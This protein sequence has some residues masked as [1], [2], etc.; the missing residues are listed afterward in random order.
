M[1]T[2]HCPTLPT[3]GYWI[4]GHGTSQPYCDFRCQSGYQKVGNS[5]VKNT[6]DNGSTNYPHCNSCP[7]GQI[8][9]HGQ[10]IF[11]QSCGTKPSFSSWIQGHGNAYPNCTWECNTGF[12]RSGNACLPLSCQNGA[13]NYPNCNACANGQHM[14]N[15]SCVGGGYNWY[16]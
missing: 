3:H 6:C 16:T 9:Q 14:V 7:A 1:N 4:Y 5:C 12:Y 2:S 11:A 15:G 10:C 13:L 8:Y